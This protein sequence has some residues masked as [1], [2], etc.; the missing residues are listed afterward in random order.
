MNQLVFLEQDQ[1]DIDMT[2]EFKETIA[3]L[4]LFF[5]GCLAYRDMRIFDLCKLIF[6]AGF[7]ILFALRIITNKLL[8]II[9]MIVLLSILYAMSKE[10]LGVATIK[11]ATDL[12]IGVS[13]GVLIL[14]TILIQFI[15]NARK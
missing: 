7:V 8:L 13:V 12:Y 5:I 3:V 6:E 10:I 2:R 9:C 4:L 1:S 11:L 15:Y 14:I